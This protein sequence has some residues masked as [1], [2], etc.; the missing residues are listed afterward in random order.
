MATPDVEM[1]GPDSDSALRESLGPD[2]LKARSIVPGA[3]RNAPPKRR[4]LAHGYG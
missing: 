4:Q 3:Y 1:H 2:N